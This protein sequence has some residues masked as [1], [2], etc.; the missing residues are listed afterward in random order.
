MDPGTSDE[1]SLGEVVPRTDRHVKTLKFLEFLGF[2]FLE[3]L[4]LD[5]DGVGNYILE[6][7][8]LITA[9]YGSGL[10][11]GNHSVIELVDIKTVVKGGIPDCQL[12]G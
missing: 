5:F 8:I 2:C 6:V 1:V 4:G 10:R 3:D 7:T 12:R 9:L 11:K